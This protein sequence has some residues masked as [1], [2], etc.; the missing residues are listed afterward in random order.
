M[1][2]LLVEDS[3]PIRMENESALHRAGY[4]VICAEDGESALKLAQ[5]Q[6]PELIL[7]D[8]ILPK[9]SGPDVLKHLK[10]DP[11][12]ADIPVVVL[13]LHREELSDAGGW[14]ELA[15]QDAGEH[16]LPHQPQARNSVLERS[17]AQ[18]RHPKDRES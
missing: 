4:E 12:T 7:L 10:K 3:K 1:R 18:V 11:M 5:A 17:R 15:A 14:N 16:P 13:R 2:V 6:K 8:M 9:M